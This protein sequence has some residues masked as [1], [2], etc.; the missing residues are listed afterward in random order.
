MRWRRERPPADAVAALGPGEGVVSWADT[1]DGAVVLATQRGIWWPDDGGYRLIGWQYVTKATWQDDVLSVIEGDVTDDGLIVDLPVVRAQLTT[2][3]DLP[4]AIRKRVE[5]NIVKRE[6]VRVDGGAVRF[7]GRRVPG[8]DRVQWWARL[9]PGTPPT[10][11][12]LSAVQARLVRLADE[13]AVT[14]C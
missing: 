4:P 7:V 6:L 14:S 8:E 10:A 5:Q 9:E 1:S 11:D 2:P 12:V 3:R 13:W